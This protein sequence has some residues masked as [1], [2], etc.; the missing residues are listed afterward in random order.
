M[1]ES[2]KT[3]KPKSKRLRPAPTSPET[4]KNATAAGTVISPPRQTSQN[5]FALHDVMELKTM[6]SR[7]LR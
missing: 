3:L 1:G 4:P 5:S 7:F 2:G 6:S